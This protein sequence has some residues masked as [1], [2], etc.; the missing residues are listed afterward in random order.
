[1]TSAARVETVATLTIDGHDVA[2]DSGTY[3]VHDPGRPGEVVVDAPCA[4]AAQ[5]DLAVRSADD[6]ARGWAETSLDD[7]RRQVVAAARA[8][9]A[10][11]E[12]SDLATLLTRENGKVLSE[13]QFEVATIAAVAETFSDLAPAALSPQRFSGGGEVTVHPY[14]VVAALL[15]FNWPVSVLVSKVAPALIAGNTVV[16]KPPPTCPGAVLAVAHT[17][18]AAL[19]PGVLNTVN[20]PGVDIGEALVGHPSVSMVSIT[21]GA[22]TGRAVMQNAGARLVPGL[23]EL[24]GN[25]AAIVAPDVEPDEALADELLAAALLTSGQVCMALKRLY[26]PAEHLDAFTEALVARAATTVTGHG[27]TDGT[28]VG[29]VHTAHAAERAEA[30]LVEAATF[31]ATVH[32]PGALRVGLAESGGHYVV[33]AVVAGPPPDAAI[34]REEQFAPLLPVLGYRDL[35]EAVAAANDSRYGLGASVWSGDDELTETIARRLHAGTVFRN[36][37]GPGALDPRLPFGGWKES[38]IGSEYGAEGLRAYTR[39]RA[40]PPARPLPGVAG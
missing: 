15:P 19:P 32:R 25:D 1:M 36:A 5:V 24:G 20:G 14:G 27:L 22:R 7:R 23:L 16:V 8:A 3:P 39:S 18:A 30:Q 33:P 35:D 11:S 13:S 34:V 9:T 2:G 4:S 6:A 17:M 31:G 10:T 26:V 29:P 28:T 40:L 12:E 38:G 37:H 21:G